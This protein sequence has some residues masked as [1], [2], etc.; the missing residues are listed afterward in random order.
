MLSVS[1][2]TVLSRA[3][4]FLRLMALAAVLGTGIVA[5]AYTVSFLLPSLIYE[6]FLGGIFYSIF[7]PILVDRI[8]QHGEEDAQRL[9][10]ALFTV[11][12]PLLAVVCIVGIVFAEP[13]IGLATDWN[14]TKALSPEEK[15]RIMDVAVIFFRIFIF[16]I[17]LLGLN[18]IATGVLQSHRRFFLPTFAPVL[19]NLITVG[20]FGAY[21]LVAGRNPTL[22]IYVLAVGTTMG[23]AAMALALVPTMWRLGYKP[24]PEFGHPALAHAARLAGPMLVLVAASVGLQAVANYYATSFNASNELWLAFAVFSLPYGVF[25]VAIVTTLMPELSEQHSRGDTVSYRDTLSLGLRLVAFVVVPSAI[26]MI[27][28]AKPIVGLLYERGEFTAQDTQTVATLLTAYAV[29]LLGYGIYFLLVRAFYSR[30]NTITPAILNVSLFSLYT[31]SV[32]L[33]TQTTAVGVVG[34]VLALSATYAL[35]ALAALAAMRRAI[36]RVGGR[37]LLLSLGKILLAGAAMYAVAWAGATLLGPGAEAIERAFIIIVVGGTSVAAYLG[38]ALL[39]KAEELK[40]A[41]TL[42]RQRVGQTEG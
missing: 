41:K 42:L 10:N 29:G 21:A 30:Q 11:A 14:G 4:G 22:A 40:W 39:L 34:V 18:T 35:L 37:Q 25:V 9:T 23:V 13:I 8:T 32:Y 27:V 7:I 2:A 38:A 12:V 5:Q 17:L 15:R 36:K 31:V 26:G 16:Q 33:I 1:A 28:L 3:T 24:R 20:S 6:L 19:N